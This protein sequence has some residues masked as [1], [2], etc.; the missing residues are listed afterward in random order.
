MAIKMQNYGLTWTDANGVPH[1]TVCSY[2]K[3]SAE[4]RRQKLEADGCT[5]VRIVETKPG[6][7]LQPQ[8]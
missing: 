6:E 8:A 2:D 3:T 1:A 4:H 5:S 7:L